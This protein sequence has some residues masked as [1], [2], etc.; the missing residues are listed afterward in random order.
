M[1]AVKYI[2]LG[3]R[4]GVELLL[5]FYLGMCIAQLLD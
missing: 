5:A 4:I 3:I 2:E 1:D